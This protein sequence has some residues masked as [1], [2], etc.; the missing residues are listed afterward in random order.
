MD[1]RLDKALAHSNLKSA[2]A[3]QRE[4]LKLRYAE[5][6]MFATNGGFFS[7]TPER[8]VFI[9]LLCRKGGH[10]AASGFTEAVLLDDKGNPVKIDNLE[11]LRDELIALYHEATNELLTEMA[12]LRPARTVKK[13]VGIE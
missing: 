12:K 3:R 8:I 10:I 9:D 11:A 7:A 5:Q 2:F 1:D 6:I 13:A 4:N